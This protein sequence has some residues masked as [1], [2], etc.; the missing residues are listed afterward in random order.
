MCVY[1]VLTMLPN[2]TFSISSFIEH[3]HHKQNEESWRWWT[4]VCLCRQSFEWTNPFALCCFH[5]Y[6]EHF[7][8]ATIH[9]INRSIMLILSLLS[10]RIY[11]NREYEPCKTYFDRPLHI[12]RPVAIR[13]ECEMRA[14]KLRQSVASIT[15]HDGHQWHMTGSCLYISIVDTA[16]TVSTTSGTAQSSN[17]MNR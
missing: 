2:F 6:S 8:C 11:S 13:N 10:K 3:R 5:F 15:D 17:Q 12:A 7:V 14:V 16:K 1:C 9:A 4:A